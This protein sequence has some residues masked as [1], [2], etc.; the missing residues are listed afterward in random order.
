MTRQRIIF[1]LMAAAV[2]LCS[3]QKE[4]PDEAFL[5]LANP[6]LK[7]FG[8]KILE[9]SPSDCQLVYTPSDRQFCVTKDDGTR[10]FT[11]T[12]DR[13]PSGKGESVSADI[14]WT[15]STGLKTKKFVALEVCR[16]E[17]DKIWLWNSKQ[18]I[19]VSLRILY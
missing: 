9:Y 2:L 7:V 4:T 10:Y 6:E 19:E 16:I 8:R 15:T 3:C 5:N 17:G 11:V 13:L 12:L 18:N 1:C 14:S